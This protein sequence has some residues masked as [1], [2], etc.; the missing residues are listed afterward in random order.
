MDPL[1]VMASSV[2]LFDGLK[3][4][5]RFAQ[6]VIR[7]DDERSDFRSRFNSVENILSMLKQCIARVPDQTRASWMEAL[8][9]EHSPLRGLLKE[10]TKMI[11]ILKPKETAF[12]QKAKNFMW[13]SEKKHMDAHFV[14]I[15]GYCQQI[16][17]ILSGAAFEFSIDN[18]EESKDAHE[19]TKQLAADFRE[20]RQ[21]SKLQKEE[22]DRK[23]IEKWL[24][25]LD[26]QAH[27]RDI[28]ETSV[29][30]GGWFLDL[31]EFVLWQDGS[32][33]SLRCYGSMGTG[34]TVLSS[35]V[36]NHLT[37][38]IAPIP[39][40]VLYLEQTPVIPHTPKNILGSLLKQLIQLKGSIPPAVR[41]AWKRAVRVDAK[42]TLPELTEL[43]AN[44]VTS[45]DR[46][47]VVIDALD[48][49]QPDVRK[50]I[51]KK[52]LKLSPDKLKLL[53]T[54]RRDEVPPLSNIT[55]D[56]CGENDLVVYYR[57][58]ECPK[59][60]HFDL[61]ADCR[62]KGEGCDVDDEHELSLPNK[63][64][65][66][67]RVP[68]KDLELYVRNNI[69]GQMPDEDIDE[70]MESNR[71]TSSPLG[72]LCSDEPSLMDFLVESIVD[73]CQGKFLLAKLYINSVSESWTKG[74]IK[75]AATQMHE[76]KY[77]L[78]ETINK[79]YDAD[80]DNRL[81]RLT[82]PQ[83]VF[84]KRILS[85]VYYAQR[86]LRFKELQHALAVTMVPG[87]TSYPADDETDEQEILSMTK[88]FI[89]IGQ[90][91]EGN[92]RFDDRT[93]V[94]YFDATRDKWFPRGQAELANICLTYLSYGEFAKP[95]PREEFI[96]KEET[97]NFLSY[98]VDNWG[99]H[100]RKAGNELVEPTAR[101]LQDD[102]RM[103]A[104]IQAAWETNTDGHQKW[105][106][107]RDIHAL[108]IC[109]W[110]DL[111]GLL[112]SL[113]FNSASLDQREKTYAQTPLIYA[114][115][116]GNIAIARRL[117]SLGASPN[118]VSQKGKSALHE[119]IVRKDPAMV[120]LLLDPSHGQITD[121]NSRDTK[122][123]N[124]TPLMIAIRQKSNAI[125]L[126][127]LT[128]P[129][130]LINIADRF[131]NTALSLASLMDMQDVVDELLC[132]QSV[133]IDA[134]EQG[135]GRSAL[136]LA[137]ENGHPGIAKALLKSGADINLKDS[138]GGTAAFRAVE[139]GKFEV[140]EVL[141]DR[142]AN[143]EIKDEH[144]RTL[145]HRAAECGREQ[146]ID[147]LHNDRHLSIDPRDKY[148]MTPLHRACAMG[149]VGAADLLLE[150]GADSCIV[151]C[152]GRTPFIVAW[153]YSQ[154]EIMD[155]CEEKG[156]NQETDSS[157]E[158]NVEELPIWS[159]IQAHHLD[160]LVD[161]KTKRE[162]E[163]NETEP[164]TGRTHFHVAIEEND[165]ETAASILSILLDCPAQKD[166]DKPDDLKQTPMHLAAMYRHIKCTK[167]LISNN[168]KLNEI[169]RFGRTPLFAAFDNKDYNIAIPLLEA[170][171]TI[172]PD[173]IIDKQELLFA[174]IQHESAKA[175]KN[176]MDLKADRLAQDEYGR[177]PDM[178][179]KLIG[180]GEILR[181][182]QPYRSFMWEA[183]PSGK[184]SGNRVVVTEMEA[185]ESPSSEVVELPEMPELPVSLKDIV[186][187]PFRARGL[188]A[189]WEE[190]RKPVMVSRWSN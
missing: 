13:H 130:I 186:F 187:R 9:N 168:A 84:A 166:I 19:T 51:E 22:A 4:F 73:N 14:T 151:D 61:C 29:E 87:A 79:L 50:Y 82:P 7:A 119:A 66:A 112:P 26:F 167:L 62:G 86:K 128:H 180:N 94:D 97:H 165:D 148:G 169:D 143:L 179:A 171:A 93:L 60:D 162:P 105:D 174:A 80:L 63:L 161:A 150:Y 5:Y 92:V 24:S 91:S 44:E 3:E 98:A 104:Y 108:H 12:K 159:L 149:Q 65:V 163:F 39:T 90:D 156:T 111:W 42:P 85:I 145:L 157:L 118:L 47:H 6:D 46:V 134:V 127:L 54:A 138:R 185:G 154:E 142:G 139:E 45:Y 126:T 158:L 23:T 25:G 59:D 72:K 141:L 33:N 34:K 178:F 40:L 190:E 132:R 140:F 100:V 129:D 106:V 147:V 78:A 110:F 31:P 55:C 18:F 146:I 69:Q 176:L 81:G 35:I 188:Q 2:A 71:R 155:L 77:T 137:A 184:G 49:A 120:K 131:G 117:L 152:F 16:Q 177:T 88:G 95:C 164:G 102:E 20:Q 48:E 68:D 124:R 74:Q 122:R 121:V 136:I 113:N 144:D 58:L 107:R 64:D 11:T 99:D 173:S 36:V 53:V 56:S 52:F 172:P 75:R 8:E 10:M 67:V 116:R 41:E 57:C 123:G 160:L 189:D 182:L 115:R 83:Q 96:E 183:V 27:Q 28:F 70:E 76:S 37:K 101:F 114:S 32:L 17:I 181:V 109:A 175:V 21:E 89:T 153:Q 38:Q 30:T 15:T 43:F 170:G 135:G 103:Q 125:A 133:N 1:S